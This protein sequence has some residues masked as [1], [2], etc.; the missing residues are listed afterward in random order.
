MLEK[1]NLL[2]SNVYYENQLARYKTERLNEGEPSP[3]PHR[4][5]RVAEVHPVKPHTEVAT[6]KPYTESKPSP[7]AGDDRE[8]DV[9][10]K[11]NNPR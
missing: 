1:M 9:P 2:P 5:V 11:K 8:K 6:V 10:F 3:V 4:T 7:N